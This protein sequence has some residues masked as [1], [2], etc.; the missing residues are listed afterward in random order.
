MPSLKA[1]KI[2][3]AEI[4]ISYLNKWLLNK[5]RYRSAHLQ[6]CEFWWRGKKVYTGEKIASLAMAND[7]WKTACPHVEE[8]N[9]VLLSQPAHRWTAMD[10]TSWL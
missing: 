5:N 9:L 4:D 8:W 3:F 6:S 7:T 1:E 2:R 10:Q